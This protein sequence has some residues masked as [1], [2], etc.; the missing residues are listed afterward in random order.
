MAGGEDREAEFDR[1]FAEKE[2]GFDRRF[3]GK[4]AEFER[5]GRAASTAGTRARAPAAALEMAIVV[6]VA[7]SPPAGRRDAL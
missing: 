4:E 5:R 7:S 1:L 6:L 3:E 2:A